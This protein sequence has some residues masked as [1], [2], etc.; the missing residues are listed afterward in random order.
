MCCYQYR[1]RVTVQPTIRCISGIA[2]YIT[3][4]SNEPITI[5]AKDFFIDGEAIASRLQTYRDNEYDFSFRYPGDWRR[6]VRPLDMPSIVVLIAGQV[7]DGVTPCVAVIATPAPPDVSNE[8][9]LGISKAVFQSIIENDG[10]NN[11]NILDFGIKELDGKKYLTCHFQ[12]TMVD[13]SR[14]EILQ[15]A[16]IHNGEEFTIRA[17]GS[18]TNFDKNRP[19][20]DS[21][22]NSFQFD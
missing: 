18:Q 20:F 17:I 12:A 1:V 9:L 11:V 8:V 14:V 13:D 16:H 6:V 5:E 3:R 22:I 15:F 2:G 7:D 10:F 19:T 21:I 4:K